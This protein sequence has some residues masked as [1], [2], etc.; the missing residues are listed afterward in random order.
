MADCVSSEWAAFS[1][2]VIRLSSPHD[3]AHN[4][5]FFA[6]DVPGD[7]PCFF[8]S[9]IKSGLFPQ[10]K[11]DALALRADVV[12]FMRHDGYSPMMITHSMLRDPEAA[13]RSRET[14]EEFIEYVA[15]PVNHVG[16]L[17]AI[18]LTLKY[19]VR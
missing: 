6:R 14:Y 18:A 15:N 9:V 3:P 11:G 2:T 12:E 8:W 7:G 4:G 1:S 10:F 19:Q 5:T 16:T 13:G 17:C